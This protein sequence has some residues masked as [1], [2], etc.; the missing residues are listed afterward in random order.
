MGWF[1]HRK[2]VWRIP[3]CVGPG[4]RTAHGKFGR[5]SHVDAIRWWMENLY[6]SC[7]IRF[8]TTWLGRVC[9]VLLE[10]GP[11]KVMFEGSSLGLGVP[12]WLFQCNACFSWAWSL[13]W[14]RYISK[15]LFFQS[16]IVDVVSKLAWVALVG[17]GQYE[18][19]FKL[20]C[21]LPTLRPGL[22]FGDV[23]LE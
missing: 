4:Y 12:S 14:C 18:A 2:T 5:W 17:D 19:V 3:L 6:P 10:S 16:Y 15:S 22:E 23:F 8:C 9:C 20:K 7:R 13:W 1:A 11:T 21:H